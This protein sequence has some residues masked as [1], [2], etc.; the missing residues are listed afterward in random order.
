MIDSKY[1]VKYKMPHSVVHIVDNS[2]YNGPLQV[3][4]AED[5]SLLASIVVTGAPMGADNQMITINRSDVLGVA[6]SMANLSADDIKRYGQGVTY[7]GSLIEQGGPVRFMRVTP[8]DATY[9]VSSLVVQWRIDDTDN[10]LHVRFKVKEWPEE[11]QRDRFKNTAKVNEAL[12]K[13]FKVDNVEVDSQGI[14]TQRA[15][16]NFISAGRGSVYN[17]M[18]N[19]INMTAQA[20]R[21]ANVRYEFDTI[22]TRTNQ[23][24]ERFFASLVNVNN[25][26][27]TDAIESVNTVVSRRVAGSSITVPYVN[28]AAVRELYS[29]YMAY[30]KNMLDVIEPDE[31]I[32]NAYKAMNINIF[33][34]VFG[35]YIYNGTDTTTKM[36]FYQVDMLDTDIPEIPSERRLCVLNDPTLFNASN[37]EVLYDKVLESTYGVTRAGDSVHVGDLYLTTPGNSTANPKISII[38]SINQYTGNVTSMTIPR[39]FA[40]SKESNYTELGSGK[41]VYITNIVSD[42]KNPY[43]A[44]ASSATINKMVSQGTI[45]DGAVIAANRYDTS[46]GTPVPISGF[47]LYTVEVDTFE[48][49]A[50]GL[51]TKST[52][53]HLMDPSFYYKML[54]RESHSGGIVGTGNAMGFEW[55]SVTPNPPKEGF[56][57]DAA[58]NRPGATVVVQETVAG[59]GDPITVNKIYVND[60]DRT[61]DDNDNLTAHRIYVADAATHGIIGTPPTSVNLTD[62]LMGSQFDIQVY[63]NDAINTWKVSGIEIDPSTTTKVINAGEA[64]EEKLSYKVGDQFYVAVIANANESAPGSAADTEQYV[65]ETAD[66]TYIA[67]WQVVNKTTPYL[68]EAPADWTDGYVNYSKFDT[69]TKRIVN[70]ATM[71]KLETEPA[72]FVGSDYYKIDTVTGKY[73]KGSSEET[74]WEADKWYSADPA[75]QEF[76]EDLKVFKPGFIDNWNANKSRY[77]DNPDVSACR[78]IVTVQGVNVETGEITDI[79]ISNAA[80][81]A[82][83]TDASIYTVL[84]NSNLDPTTHPNAVLKGVFITT[85]EDDPRITQLQPT[86]KLN[87]FKV[88][89]ENSSPVS[90][91][92]YTITGSIGSLF[93]IQADPTVIPSN[94]YSSTYGI[95]PTTEVGGVKLSGGYTGF[96]DDPDISDIE[97]KWKYSALLVKAFRGQ[98]DPRIQSP[99]RTPAKFMFDAGYNTIVGS[100]ILPYLTYTPA[101]IINASIIFTDDEKEEILFHPEIIEGLKYEDIDVKQAMYDLMIYRCYHGMPEEMRPQGPGSGLSLHLDSGVTDANTAMLVN[102]SFAKRFDNP[103]ASWDIGG[104]V[105]VE[106]GLSYTFTK[107]IADNLIR[108]TRQTSINKPYVGDLTAITPDRYTTYFPDVDTTD[109]ELRELL[110]NSGG[111]AWIMGPDGSLTRRSQRTLKRDSDTSDLM[112]ESNM[113]TLSQLTYLL[114]NKIDAFLLEYNDDAI[115]KTLSDNVNNT[116]SNWVG[117]L[118]QNLQIQFVRDINP[119]DGGEIL[120][121]YCDVTFR[122]LILRVP[123]IVNINRRDTN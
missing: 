39:V 50:T 73:V 75:T 119:T 47:D 27:R 63:N 65:V 12:V 11:I 10:K 85:N 100:T 33:D 103:N 110:Y 64:N 96:F 5:P 51:K 72:S 89:T 16:I 59:E 44:D 74:T 95:N 79:S 92:R 120:V 98:I 62:D 114:Q 21:P 122:G 42:I 14:W 34:M 113:R 83:E 112:Q 19:A 1:A 101:D 77:T 97:F 60:Y 2:S 31:F 48:D 87:N 111:N 82:N 26:D 4:T 99:N 88:V 53:L 52:T 118:V 9:A 84:T 93:R 108:H 109:W 71:T 102:T 86:F 30:Y 6:Y 81:Y 20:K 67:Y 23:V 15:F 91:K 66:E 45:S 38:T 18:A 117:T 106:T 8:E 56:Q 22:D 41:S 40:L 29:V 107:Q 105:D 116:F 68:T 24:V 70:V 43:T 78:T 7:A 61:A 46:T 58:W 57:P 115:I 17:Y 13:Y 3:V 80:P 32:S 49:A 25:K 36:P 76:S 54:D 121:C 37:P 90:I 123:I 35:N 94:Y 28:T 104:W 69:A 55:T